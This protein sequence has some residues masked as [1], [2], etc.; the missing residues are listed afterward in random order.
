MSSLVNKLIFKKFQVK[1][2]LFN[3]NISNV[4]EGLNK[5]TKEPVAMKFEKIGGKFELLESEAYL[6]LL[7]KGFGIPRL[8]SFG[9]ITN[10]KILVEELLGPS[11]Y[12]TIEIKNNK[13]RLND[14][15]LIALQ[16]LDRLEYIHSKDV[17]HKDIKPFNFIFGK[18]DPNIIYVIDFGLSKKYRSSRTG[19]HIKFNKL[20]RIY[21]SFRYM[22]I[23]CNRGYEQSR[24]DDLESLGYMLIYL[25][26]KCLP[27]S[28]IVDNSPE[29]KR[30]Q[31]KKILVK[32]IKITP[33]ELCSGLPLEFADYIKY[34]RKLEFEDEPNY[35]YLKHLFIAILKRNEQIIDERFINLIEFSWLKKKKRRE[36]TNSNPKGISH[37]KYSDSKKR[38]ESIHKRLFQQIKESLDMGK[39]MEL[40]KIR[41]SNLVKFSANNICIVPN[42][43]NKNYKKKSDTAITSNIALRKKTIKKIKE[44]I[45]DKIDKNKIKEK[46][47]TKKSLINELDF[48][49]NDSN[50]IKK[51]IFYKKMINDLSMKTQDKNQFT[52]N[53][54]KNRIH[55]VLNSNDF[56]NINKSEEYS[57]ELYPNEQLSLKLYIPLRERNEM[58]KPRKKIYISM[59][60][61]PISLSINSASKEKKNIPFNKNNYQQ[62]NINNN[63]F[64]S[65]IIP[66]RQKT[67]LFSFSSKHNK[68]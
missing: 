34:C 13:T 17:I 7:L 33:E 39:S 59:F 19:K 62:V 64:N 56:I 42:N 18:N 25:A 3:T 61:N 46:A 65:Y 40:P 22:S 11:I 55:H 63:I 54:E 36:K 47:K 10:Y 12:L 8:I 45:N 52:R 5:I 20:K 44:N 9:K 50:P 14:V 23:N 58:K 53:L 29:S 60:N 41:Q 68:I 24:K 16:I 27:W 32:K 15:C 37:S 66:L 2:L 6:L 26:K 51:G 28:D 43:T 48:L 67:D 1:K 31:M 49:K 35:D 57:H 38:K 4:Y 30:E 21:G